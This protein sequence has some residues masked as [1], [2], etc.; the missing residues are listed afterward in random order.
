M[1]E[2]WNAPVYITIITRSAIIRRYQ[3]PG[4]IIEIVR[5]K[6]VDVL[7]PITSLPWIIVHVTKTVFKSLRNVS[8]YFFLFSSSDFLSTHYATHTVINNSFREN[9]TSRLSL[10]SCFAKEIR[11]PDH[12]SSYLVCT[13]GSSFRRGRK[14]SRLCR[15]ISRCP[16]DSC[17]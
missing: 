8:S 13:G 2:S 16:L 1:D 17:L 14:R 12:L 3:E 7:W 9:S 5:S 10:V 11:F 4:N 15:S 6:R